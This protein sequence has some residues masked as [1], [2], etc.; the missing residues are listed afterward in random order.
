M[1]WLLLLW[2]IG[3]VL[4]GFSIWAALMGV[5]GVLSRLGR[6]RDVERQNQVG[7]LPAT[8]LSGGAGLTLH[9][10]NRERPSSCVLGLHGGP[11]RG[12]RAG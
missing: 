9:V 7:E 1:A 12:L 8:A 5:G 6:P 3:A 10:V 2:I 4:F 11:D